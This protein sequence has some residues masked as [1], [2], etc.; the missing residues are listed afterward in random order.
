MSKREFLA[1]LSP[2]ESTRL[3]ILIGEVIKSLTE[4]SGYLPD[5]VADWIAAQNDDWFEAFINSAMAVPETAAIA[6]PE[7]SDIRKALSK[8]HM[9]ILGE[10]GAGKST[11]VKYLVSQSSASAIVLDPHASANDWKGMTVIGAGREYQEI[12]EEVNR[13][14]KLMDDRYKA[15]KKGQLNFVPLLVIIDEFPAIAAALGKSF[16]EAILL[17]VRE[18]RKIGIKLIILS[19]GSEVKSLGIEGQGSIRECF[20]IVSL[21]KFATARAKSLGD[22]SIKAALRAAKY[23]AMLDDL[24]CA[25]PEID[26]V[27]LQRFPLPPDY[28]S[29]LTASHVDTLKP[30][31]SSVDNVSTL[32]NTSTCQRLSTPLSTI[33][34]YAKKQNGF[35]SARTVKQNIRMFRD[36]STAEIRDYF[37]QLVDN[38]YGV[39]KGFQDNLEFY[40]TN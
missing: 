19:I 24:P 39:V 6:S 22:E 10:T 3:A 8:P 14:V 28:Q 35:V 20:A 38:N 27:D 25:L 40:T 26:R 7:F 18:A 17:L 32:V 29:L 31:F 23:A 2:S 12:G 13:L 1:S 37:Q 9:L 15:R 16:T 21:G 11:L 30:S 34:E 36:T 33:I 5:A 4:Q